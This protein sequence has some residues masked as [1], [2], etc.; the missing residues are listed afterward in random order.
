MANQ[1]DNQA[2]TF[3]IGALLGGAVGAVAAL[4]LAPKSGRDL[5]QDIAER[6]EDIVDKAQGYF[7]EDVMPA[8]EEDADDFVNEGRLRAE[9]IVTS[10]RKQAETLLS[11]AEQVLRDARSRAQSMKEQD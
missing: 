4:L 8:D 2:G 1:Q 3:I 7:K 10:A 6:S 9:R 5:R 11:N